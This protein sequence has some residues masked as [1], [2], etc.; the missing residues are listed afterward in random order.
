MLANLQ[1]IKVY[2]RY[3][4]RRWLRVN[5]NSKSCIFHKHE[6]EEGKKDGHHLH[7]LKNLNR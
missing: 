1:S 2:P 4:I 6:E 3:N 7:R 5:K